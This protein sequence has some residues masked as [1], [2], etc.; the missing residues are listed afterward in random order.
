MQSKIPPNQL[1]TKGGS[2]LRVSHFFE[3]RDG[4]SGNS[5]RLA[6]FLATSHFEQSVTPC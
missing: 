4:A 2:T 1:K 6:L 3:Q 5:K